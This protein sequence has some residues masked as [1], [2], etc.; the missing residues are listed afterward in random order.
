LFRG[1]GWTQNGEPSG[2]NEDG[3]TRAALCQLRARNIRCQGGG[4]ALEFPYR[5]AL[6]IADAPLN[7]ERHP[8]DSFLTE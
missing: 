8:L 5:L 7:R 4:E 3:G 1:Y 6:H 2:R